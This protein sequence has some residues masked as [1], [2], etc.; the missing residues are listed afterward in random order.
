MISGVKWPLICSAEPE[1]VYKRQSNAYPVIISINLSQDKI[2]ILYFEHELKIDMGSP[3]SYTELYE[4]FSR[5]LESE[6]K[7]EYEKRFSLE[8]L[9]E[10]LGEQKKEVFIETRAVLTDRKQHWISAQIIHVD[11]PY[12]CLLYT[13][14]CV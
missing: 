9:K 12:S 11:N 14:R 10:T 2:D 8:T 7:E 3:R 13:S 6:A 5:I 1:D 4:A